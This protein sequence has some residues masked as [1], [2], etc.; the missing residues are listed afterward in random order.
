MKKGPL[1]ILALSIIVAGA[2]MIGGSVKTNM[3]VVSAD[4]LLFRDIRFSDTSFYSNVSFLSSGKTFRR[5]KYEVD[6]DKLY[7]T[8]YGGLA[9]SRFPNGNFEIDIRDDFEGVNSVYLQKGST[10]TKIYPLE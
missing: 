7:I 5:Y 2:I 8:V 4:E 9:N 6:Q 10:T 1:I 3:N